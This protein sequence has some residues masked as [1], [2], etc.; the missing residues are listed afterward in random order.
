MSLSKCYALG[1]ADAKATSELFDNEKVSHKFYVPESYLEAFKQKDVGKMYS[2]LID[3]Y[4][5]AMKQVEFRTDVEYPGDLWANF[6]VYAHRENGLLEK[7]QIIV[8]LNGYVENV[9]GDL[10]PE[11]SF[12]VF[13]GCKGD[14]IMLGPT[15][16]V[17]YSCKPN[18]EYVAGG[19]TK[20]IV[21]VKTLKT[22]RGAPREIFGQLLRPGKQGVF[23]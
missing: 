9:E 22:G 7:G 14:R 11:Q 6:G 13:G 1:A 23:L 15:S 2:Q 10:S 8:G 5:I 19:Q 21:R 18:V 3:S 20:L 4:L 17:N 16:F 12:S